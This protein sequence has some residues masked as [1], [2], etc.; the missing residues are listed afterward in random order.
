ME[1]EEEEREEEGQRKKDV[2]QE[3]SPPRPVVAK[4]PPGRGTYGVPGTRKDGRVCRQRSRIGDKVETWLFRSGAS[5]IEDRQ[6]GR[7]E[8]AKGERDRVVGVIPQIDE[9]VAVG[10]R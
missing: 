2:S 4:G 7:N 8:V 1:E 10:P 3:I 6:S 9:Q 5:R